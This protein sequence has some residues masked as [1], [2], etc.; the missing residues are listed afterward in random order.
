MTWGYFDYKIPEKK[1]DSNCLHKACL[2]NS[3]DLNITSGMFAV[4][5]QYCQSVLWYGKTIRKLAPPGVNMFQVDSKTLCSPSL[6]SVRKAKRQCLCISREIWHLWQSRLP[7]GFRA[8]TKGRGGILVQAA[9]NV[10]PPY[11]EGDE[12]KRWLSKLRSSTFLGYPI[13]RARS[14]PLPT[15]CEGRHGYVPWARSAQSEM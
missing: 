4:V 9:S 7:R 8:M 5:A 14:L 2:V 10:S 1:H 15:D 11:G 13:C 6:S 12:K 3:D